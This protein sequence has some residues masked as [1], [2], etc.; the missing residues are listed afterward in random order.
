MEFY[1][2]PLNEMS[3]EKLQP[4]SR[5][6]RRMSLI[7][8]EGSLVRQKSSHTESAYGDAEHSYEPVYGNTCSIESI[9]L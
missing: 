5:D 8:E 4:T 3:L 1:V 7:Q 9:T 6:R 2:R